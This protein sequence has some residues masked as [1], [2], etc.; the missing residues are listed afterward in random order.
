MIGLFSNPNV[1]VWGPGYPR[2]V[3][4]LLAYAAIGATYL[5]YVAAYYQAAAESTRVGGVEFRFGA[6]FN[7]WLKFYAVT[8]GLAIVTLGL[9]MLVYDFRKWR[10]ITAHLEA[11]GIVD[12]E[13]LTQSTTSAPREAEGILD[14]L[15]I[16]AF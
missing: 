4:P 10:F 9:A 3:V 15:D 16:G 14:A 6:E 7:D 13:R 12:V 11:Y 1:I 5:N 2:L 8:V